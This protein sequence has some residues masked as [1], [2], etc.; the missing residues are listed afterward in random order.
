MKYLLSDGS[1]V[2]RVEYYI[3]DLFKLYLSVYP[4]DIPGASGIGFDFNLV[5]VMKAD[6]SNEV[7][8]RLG[9][10]V[11]SLND[12]FSGGI[13][14]VLESYELIDDSLVKV[15][16]SCGRVRSEEIVIS[17]YNEQ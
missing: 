1:V 4:G 13:E 6:L 8:S 2:E 12:R 5:G 7:G 14:L 10:L 17:V 3:I 15:I 11:K 16:V 9:R